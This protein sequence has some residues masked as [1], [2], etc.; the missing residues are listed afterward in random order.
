MKTFRV[1]FRDTFHNCESEEQAYDALIEYLADCVKHEDVTGF[2]FELID[3][4]TP[5]FE[6][7]RE[8]I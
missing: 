4:A 1:S 3:D 5:K 2:N 6:P 8:E 7:A